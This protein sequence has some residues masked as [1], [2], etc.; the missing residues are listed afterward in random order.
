[1]LADI[2]ESMTAAWG[3]TLAENIDDSAAPVY[4]FTWLV[5][6]VLRLFGHASVDR[7]AVAHSCLAHNRT[8]VVEMT[9]LYVAVS[10]HAPQLQAAFVTARRSESLP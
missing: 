9:G 8:P 7:S 10:R 6:G 1:M 4:R 2:T 3:A 5:L